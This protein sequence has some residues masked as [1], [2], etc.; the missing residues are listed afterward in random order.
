MTAEERAEAGLQE[1]KKMVAPGWVRSV[2]LK[3]SLGLG[4]VG[5][6]CGRVIE[7]VWEEDCEARRGRRGMG[8]GDGV[9]PE[10]AADMASG[11]GSG[12]GVWFFIVLEVR[13]IYDVPQERQGE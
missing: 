7:V 12:S 11:V 13:L 5:L 2:V 4:N 8:M 1:V 6:G 9:G 10:G 3:R